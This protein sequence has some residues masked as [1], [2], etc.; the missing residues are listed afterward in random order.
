[1]RLGLVLIPMGY[2]LGHW[3]AQQTVSWADTN[4]VQGLVLEEGGRERKGEREE[5]R[6]SGKVQLLIPVGYRPIY[7]DVQLR[8]GQGTNRV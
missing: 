3:L 5:R 4:R 7:E 2:R 1:M 8:V 6:E